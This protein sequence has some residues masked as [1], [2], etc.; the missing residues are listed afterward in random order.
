MSKIHFD[1]YLKESE[2][3]NFDVYSVVFSNSKDVSVTVLNDEVESQEI[4]N[5]QVVGASGLKNGKRGGFSTDAIDEKTKEI[6]AK[7]TYN[8]SLYGKDYKKEYYVKGGLE[9]QKADILDDSFKP[10][11]LKD[12][13]E[14]CLE[15]SKYVHSLDKRIKDVEVSLD[16]TQVE[17]EKHNSL[18]LNVSEKSSMYQSYIGVTVVGEDGDI[19]SLGHGE[20][21]FISL[22]EIS[23]LAKESA[24]RTAK[25]CIDLLNS[26]PVK[27][28]NYKVI[29]SP[30]CVSILLGAYLSH[31]DAK[32]IDKHLSIF[33]NKEGKRICSDKLSI[34][35]IP[36][37][38][39][40]SSSSFDGDGNPTKDFT[41]VEH[42]ILKNIFISQEMAYELK[43]ENN[44]TGVSQ[45]HGS[46]LTIK[47]ESGE[48]EKE[49][50]IKEIGDGIYITNISGVST[51]LDN[52]TL[53]FSLP[54]EGYIIKRGCIEHST[55]MDIVSGNLKD[56]FN[57]II[58]VGND[59]KN[60]SGV[61]T[62]SIAVSNVSIS[63]K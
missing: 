3:Y 25:E 21:S 58:D 44:G 56:L 49:E 33:E 15:L 57:N 27:S 16:M 29:F 19:R 46:F 59:E 20:N 36:H 37:V 48:K 2:K 9:Y 4:G 26:Q 7:E 17:V 34:F 62:P 8:S 5:S 31:L 14:R 1:D 35:H 23:N 18:S 22:D 11:S 45:G 47:V 41:I 12:L 53:E 30:Y 40:T 39:A 43:R 60:Y 55:S 50:L 54:C 42:G 61:F 24:K 38:R 32:K 6:L 10:A 28:S 52:R 51:G 13:R 63:G